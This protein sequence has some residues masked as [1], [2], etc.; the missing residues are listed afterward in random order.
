[1]TETHVREWIAHRLATTSPGTANNNLRALQQWFNW[2]LAEGE[3]DV[4]LMATP[5]PPKVPEQPVP[6]TPDHVMRA[7]PVCRRSPG[8]AWT[9]WT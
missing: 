6:V 7:V 1:M 9:T 4:R 8:S 2:L 3:I 5:Q